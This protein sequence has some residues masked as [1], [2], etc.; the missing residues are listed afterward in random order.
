MKLQLPKDYWKTRFPPPPIYYKTG[1]NLGKTPTYKSDY[2]KVN[3]NTQPSERGSETVAIYVTL[4]QTGSTEALHKLVTLLHKII[5]GQDLSTLPPKF[6]MTSS[7]VVEE[8]L[9]VF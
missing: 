6:G 1:V 5:R 3:I 7:M 4:F 8:G 9:Q 2:L